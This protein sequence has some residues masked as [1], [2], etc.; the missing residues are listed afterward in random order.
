[1]LSATSNGNNYLSAVTLTGTLDATSIANARERIVNGLVLN[2]A[3]NISNG[4]IV[5]L[6]SSDTTNGVQSITGNGSINLNDAG[7]WLSIEGTGSTTL[8]SGIV[9]HGQGNVGQAAFSAGN[10][11][12]VNNGRITADV[13]GGT[14][15]INTPAN[16]GILENAGLVDARNGGTMM[17][18]ANVD[19]TGGTINA[20]T[21]S[22]VVQNGVSITAG[23]ISTA[24]TGSF[25]VTNNGNNFM[26]GVT[27]AGN[28][29]M[30]SAGNARE[31]LYGGETLNGTI[32]IANGGILSLDS[33]STPN[34]T[35]TGTGTIALNDAG[36]RLS[37]EGTGV[38]TLDTGI[39]V[40]GQGNIGVA[41]FS[42]GNNT[43][44]NNGTI[45]ADVAGGTLTLNAPA[46]GG[47]V[48][49]TG[50]LEANGGT[51]ALA[52]GSDINQGRL[53]I[54]G[55]GSAVTLSGN[56]VIISSDYTNAQSGSGNSFDRHAGISGAGSILASG[57]PS[58]VISGANITGGNTAAATL[59][60]G[61]VRVGTTTFNYNVSNADATGPTLRGAIQTNV[62]GAN[63]SDARLGGTGAT[64]GTYASG[65]QGAAGA[66]LGVSFTVA[67]T[68]A[69]APLT[70]QSVNL[71]SNFDNV[72]DQKL[73]IVL[74]SNSAAY[75][76]AAGQVQTP[77]L[78]FGT[79]Q[80]GQAIS[81]NLV[82]G[83]TATGAAG[84]VED[85]N[86]AFGS[87]NGTGAASIS[88]TGSLGGILAG[89]NSTA[90][91]GTMTVSVNTQTAGTINGGIAVNYATNGTVNGVSNGLG[92]ASV[93]SQNYAVSGLIVNA[94]SPTVTTPTIALGATRVGDTPLSGFVGIS[95]AGVG[96]PQ[97]A[98][99][100]TITSN[101]A[102]VTASGS[103]N[104][105]AAGQTSTN[106]LSVGLST[107]TA[108]DFTG[109]NAKSA[110]ISLVSDAA[111]IGNCGANCQMTLGNQ[112]VAVTGKVYSPAAVQ[113]NTSAVNFG[114]VHVGDQVTAT[115]VSITNS[116]TASALSDVLR[117]S[118]G[119]ATGPFTAS[120]SFSS[121]AA[122]A[123]DTSSLT[124]GLNTST[125]GAFTGN[126]TASFVSHD[127]DLA[128]LA[129]GTKTI[130]L[131][132]TVDNYA[133]AAFE[134][135]NG[136]TPLSQSGD[137]YT[138][139]FG[140]VTQ[141]ATGP[142]DLLAV[143]NSATG[144]AD[145][146]GG[147]FTSSGSATGFSLGGFDAFS[148][149]GAGQSF[150]GLSVGLDT[151]GVGSFMDTITLHSAGSNASGYNGALD[152]LTLVLEGSVTSTTAAV[153]EPNIGLLLL[154]GLGAMFGARR[155]RGR[156]ANN[157][158]ER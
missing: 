105:L 21:G 91:N 74:A 73:N 61:N 15:A 108:G 37:I 42:S 92:V 116:G 23:T 87:S 137:T 68:G 57:T 111:N 120:G 35:I 54:G 151:S 118:I 88:G 103:V 95:N 66:N 104:L 82:V 123:T 148:G 84:Y 125:S 86:A 129:L 145:L 78:S 143:L 53:V 50:T 146:L 41:L 7:A 153:P 158:V 18:S 51:L 58:Q 22:T 55:A 121:L 85:L 106:Q 43:L 27:I 6:D 40:H 20:Q 9:I 19:N 142:T 5:S 17:L 16:G 98:L 65:A 14:L 140:T 26:T 56:N 117:G 12:L 133:R 24:G 81:Q 101:G 75:Q 135:S 113:A 11:T 60:I 3:I 154:A 109:A 1:V 25:L 38:T 90:A 130:A 46:N 119:G 47:S 110:T 89:A 126:A 83:N 70:G 122:Q 138:L 93:G 128:D 131:T 141:G 62:N 67:S 80:V 76:A 36:A 39:T 97:A 64:A 149:L 2:G 28:V 79:V 34:Q 30:A 49:G 124:V 69:L 150:S 139:N 100:A 102:P 114:V 94:A 4:G 71:T 127:G 63:L 115:G 157:S 10:N 72:A 44:V 96:T 77:A 13:A 107:A 136:G 147:S 48:T 33:T 112:Q 152:D 52:T 8:G 31:R 29:D 155:V 99:D 156:R 132:G 32:S 59:T 144:L 134:L 45:S